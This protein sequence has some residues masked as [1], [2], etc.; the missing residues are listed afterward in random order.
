MDKPCGEYK[1]CECKS[2]VSKPCMFKPGMV[3][4]IKAGFFFCVGA[5]MAVSMFLFISWK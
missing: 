4:Y 1:P 3:E 5:L 2:C